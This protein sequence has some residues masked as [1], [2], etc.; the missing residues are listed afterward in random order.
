MEAQFF[1]VCAKALTVMLAV[2]MLLPVSGPGDAAAAK[3]DTQISH[4]P[5]SYFVP[6]SRIRVEAAVTDKVGVK[7]VRCYFKAKDQADFV[8]VPMSGTGA[9]MY[10]GILPA[11]GPN[12]RTV[13]YLFLAVGGSGQPVKT[14]KFQIMKADSPRIPDWQQVST[15]GDIRVSTELPEMTEPP[16]GF[17]DSIVMDVVESSARFGIAA[18]LYAGIQSG[19][20]GG[21]VVG[22]G[23][24]AVG[25]GTA[26]AG[27]G[28]AGAAATG[29]STTAI[30]AIGTGAAGIGGVLVL[31]KSDGGGGDDGST[32]KR[33]SFS[34][35][36]EINGT[37]ARIEIR[38]DEDMSPDAHKVEAV[39]PDYWPHYDD[40]DR[41][42]DSKT[43]Y[44]TRGENSDTVLTKN[45]EIHFTLS[46]FKDQAG[47]PV[48]LDPSEFSVT[49]TSDTGGVDIEW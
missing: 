7:L 29:L 42:A 14:G 2:M 46:G 30:I 48:D 33:I 22:S 34:H 4:E 12:T 40:N 41:W 36:F 26:A 21:T 47:N 31:N 49:V 3:S 28:T 27:S 1:K 44:I 15:E 5:I 20:A 25:S 16:E 11:P 23:A 39:P 9:G 13:I 32:K 10:H 6:D 18:G 8:F 38:F 45:T 19:M 43:F 37:D 17:R 35:P 24:G